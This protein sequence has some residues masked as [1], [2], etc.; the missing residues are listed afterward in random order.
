MKHP[1]RPTFI[2]F[3]KSKNIL[4]QYARNKTKDINQLPPEKW[5]D[6]FKWHRTSEGAIFWDDLDFDWQKELLK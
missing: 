5:M 1:L 4:S 2:S 6:V 3:L